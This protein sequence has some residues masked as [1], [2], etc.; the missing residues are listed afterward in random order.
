[1]RYNIICTG[2][3]VAIG[4]A[5]SMLVLYYFFTTQCLL[6][7]VTFMPLN[8]FSLGAYGQEGKGACASFDV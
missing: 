2:I 7:F 3:H 5:L 1:M 4:H 6:L 8:F